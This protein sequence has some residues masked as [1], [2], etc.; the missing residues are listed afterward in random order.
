LVLLGAGCVLAAPTQTIHADEHRPQYTVAPHTV[1]QIIARNGQMS[2][3]GGDHF[4]G[5]RLTSPGNA[6]SYGHVLPAHASPRTV[7]DLPVRTMSIIEVERAREHPFE[8]PLA[9]VLVYW[10]CGE[11]VG[12]DQPRA[13]VAGQDQTR[14]SRRLA[15][16]PGSSASEKR[17]AAIPRERRLYARKETRLDLPSAFEG[18][19]HLETAHSRHAFRIESG[20]GFLPGIDIV[21]A[22]VSPASGVR[23]EWTP[24]PGAVA[25]FA[26]T[27]IQHAGSR[28]VVIWTSS[29]V[30]EAGWL[31]SRMHP[32]EKELGQ[33]L[34]RGVLMGPEA[35]ECTM[36][37]AVV[38][39]AHGTLVYHLSAYGA[40]LRTTAHDTRRRI[41]IDV[42][43]QPRATTTIMFPQ[44]D[45]GAAADADARVV[46]RAGGT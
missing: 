45:G 29:R 2:F 43:V 15:P 37:A 11:R 5:L 33:L 24:V 4:L 28:D 3:A 14:L 46:L 30:P 1:R 13:H 41:P 25:Y 9:R 44:I 36:P 21:R 23:I 42:Q 27:F 32:G 12:K 18:E 17:L 35:S 19:H 34:A 8:V 7:I 31:L 20:R 38:K 16:S 39:H 40:E 22:S 26:S 6:S 10:G